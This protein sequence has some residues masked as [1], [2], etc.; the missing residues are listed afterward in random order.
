VDTRRLKGVSVNYNKTIIG[1]RLTRDLEL[2]YLANQT[3]VVDGGIACNRKYKTS[4]GEER[5]ETLF[6]DF[7]VFGKQA[8]VLSK[9]CQ[10]GKELLLEGHLK[11]ES[12]EAK[13]GS[14]KRSKNV[15]VVENFQ[16]IGTRDSSGEQQ[17]SQ[18][19]YADARGGGSR[20]TPSQR[21]RREPVTNPIGDEQQFD[22][23]SIPF[24]WEGRH[25]QPV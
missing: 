20:A 1:G 13:D 12:W 19:T 15:L 18:Q 7:V 21:P 14:G 16:F 2:R 11:T 17:E 23:D 22:D 5:E 9:Y 6:Q 3:A 25:G 24:H 10:K 8:E 4:G